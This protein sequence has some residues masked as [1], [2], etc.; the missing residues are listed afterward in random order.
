MCEDKN[1]YGSAQTGDAQQ[2]APR[3]LFR[4]EEPWG[5]PEGDYVEH[6]PW[7]FRRYAYLCG[8]SVLGFVALAIRYPLI[9]AIL[10][11]VLA[12]LAFGLLTTK[13]VFRLERPILVWVLTPVIGSGWLLIF[14][15]LFQLTK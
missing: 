4:S 10:C 5:R 6:V 13:V 12:V 3:P 15:I 9:W 1:P 7:R 2:D 8:G 14:W 11:I